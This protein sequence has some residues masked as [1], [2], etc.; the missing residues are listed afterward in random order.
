[1][2]LFIL[3][4]RY[5]FNNYY[6]LWLILEKWLNFNMA[7]SQIKTVRFRLAVF[8]AIKEHHYNTDEITSVIR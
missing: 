8:G 6:S 7:C 5:F 3:V 1:M 4:V 2:L